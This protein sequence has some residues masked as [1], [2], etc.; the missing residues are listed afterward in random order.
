M[1]NLEA[2]DFVDQTHKVLDELE[3]V[4]LRGK[5]LI[6]DLRVIPSLG[7]EINVEL[8]QRFQDFDDE[9]NPITL[10]Y[11]DWIYKLTHPS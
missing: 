7:D 1:T 5:A 9:L 2:A 4:F 6:R 11:I 10:A 8:I 3:A